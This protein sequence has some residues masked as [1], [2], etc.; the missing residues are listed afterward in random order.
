[1]RHVREMVYHQTCVHQLQQLPIEDDDWLCEHCI[2]ELNTV[3][4]NFTE[5]KKL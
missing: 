4:Q 5:L 1:M 2:Q 3:E